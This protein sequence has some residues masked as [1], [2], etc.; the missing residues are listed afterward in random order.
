MKNARDL[1]IKN[2]GDNSVQSL[3]DY[4]QA[5]AGVA[6]GGGW[7]SRGAKG[8]RRRMRRRGMR[9][10]F[11]SVDFP[12][13][14]YCCSP[15]VEFRFVIFVTFQA[16]WFVLLVFGFSFCLGVCCFSK[17]KCVFINGD[18]SFS[19]PPS[20]HPLSGVEKYCRSADFSWKVETVIIDNLETL[21]NAKADEEI[22]KLLPSKKHAVTL[23]RAIAN[24]A[25]LKEPDL[26][27]ET[28]HERH[29]W[30]LRYG[31]G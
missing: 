7:A 19:H 6:E 23:K 1:F 21:I 30:P 16:F 20:A 24:M 3:A 2:V 22:L 9:R 12:K 8:E 27:W 11:V 26:F 13:R 4:E 17:R 28:Q 25:A 14:N 18:E 31:H 10:G 15:I 5:A 29:E